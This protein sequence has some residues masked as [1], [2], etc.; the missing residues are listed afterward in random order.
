MSGKRRP[1]SAAAGV[2]GWITERSDFDDPRG[3]PPAGFELDLVE[4][5][6]ALKGKHVLEVGCGNGR[7]TVELSTRAR[8]V[9]A[10]EPHAALAART[11][12]RVR[13]LELG[14]V[15]VTRQPAQ[16]GIRGGPYDA[17]LFSWSLC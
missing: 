11:R 7:L 1:A 5:S 9:T 3:Y 4:R 8:R 2:L 17:V 16:T 12:A 14:N 15:T 10:I 6:V 13:R